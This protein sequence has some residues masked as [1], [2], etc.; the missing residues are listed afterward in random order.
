MDESQT[1]LP[2]TDA[3]V[4][5][6]GDA[7]DAALVDAVLA[8]PLADAQP[9]V[10]QHLQALA[11]ERRE[12][13]LGV[14]LIA[15]WSLTDGVRVVQSD[16]DYETGLARFRSAL[17]GFEQ[18]A[19]APQ[20]HLAQALSKYA[21]AV[22]AIRARNFA[23]TQVLMRECELGIQQAGPFGAQLQPLLD[24]M[25]PEQFFAGVPAALMNGDFDGARVLAVQAAEAWR[26]VERDY[27]EPGSIDAARQAGMADF[28]LAYVDNA[29]AQRALDRFDLDALSALAAH[30]H[31]QRAAAQLAR[32]VGDKQIQLAHQ[33]SLAYAAQMELM[34][35]L[36][37]R[38]GLSLRAA[39]KPD[40]QGDLRTLARRAQ[41]HAAAAGPDAL[42]VLRN[43]EQLMQR[44]DNLERL[45]RPRR[46]DFGL[47]AGL[48]SAA[49]FLPLFGVAAWVRKQ[50]GLDIGGAQLFSSMLGL[51]LI[52]GFGY[53]ALR[54]RH[55]LF[56]GGDKKDPS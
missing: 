7:A 22:L 38:L 54:F 55:F 13:A 24:F 28:A 6:A 21:E 41:A 46:S 5:D 33:L 32:V 30:G 3:A 10:A 50:Y 19:M 18:L 48:I 16:G 29:D 45:A 23:Q 2:Q 26:R 56:G 39:L 36:G 12:Q 51:A 52:G 40:V 35:G 44:I 1:E 37:A 31:A 4:G 42:G 27:C 49:L 17:Q 53:G 11:P 25:K 8:L 34:Q 43:L 14:F 20:R 15:F 47:Y 9:V